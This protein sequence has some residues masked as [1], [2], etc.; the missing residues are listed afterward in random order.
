MLAICKNG[1]RNS[2][3]FHELGRGV[4]SLA[5]LELGYAREE[6]FGKYSMS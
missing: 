5:V 4:G 1:A 2:W 6:E 3:K